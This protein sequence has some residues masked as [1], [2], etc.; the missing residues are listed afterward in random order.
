MS[1]TST[2]LCRCTFA[3]RAGDEVE[4]IHHRRIEVPN[5][6]PYL[7]WWAS[8]GCL[9]CGGTGRP[10]RAE[11]IPGFTVSNA[12]TTVG[13]A[14][15][16]GQAASPCPTCHKSAL[17]TVGDHHRC[18]G[19]GDV[20]RDEAKPEAGEAGS[21][22]SSPPPI[23]WGWYRGKDRNRYEAAP[24]KSHPGCVSIRRPFFTDVFLEDTFRRLVAEG[25]YTYLGPSE[26]TKPEPSP[27]SPD[28]SLGVTLLQDALARSREL[29]ASN[30]AAIEAID[31]A[32]DEIGIEGGSLTITERV[33]AMAGKVTRLEWIL[34]SIDLICD[35]L[36]IVGEGR[37]TLERVS[38]MADELTR[39]RGQIRDVRSVLRQTE[40]GQ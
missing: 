30:A 13:E 39:L 23:R 17:V 35:E 31:K 37:P 22:S 16:I 33:R 38:A 32:C 1:I 12:S 2:P 9:T 3:T 5:G 10:K 25:K 15:V 24:H 21:P 4:T 20:I 36:K 19:C 40:V 34:S 26:A 11:S 18:L 27:P 28:P 29:G 6:S 8:N 14:V 7:Q